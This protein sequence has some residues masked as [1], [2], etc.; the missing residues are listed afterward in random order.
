MN[1]EVWTITLITLCPRTLS[2]EQHVG[3][4]KTYLC[5]PVFTKLMYIIFLTLNWDDFNEK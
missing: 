4:S 1:S 5:L 2:M 3:K